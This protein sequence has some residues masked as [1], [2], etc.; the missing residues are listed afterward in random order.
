[1]RVMTVPPGPWFSVA[2]VHRGWTKGLRSVL[3]AGSVVEAPLDSAL[4]FYGQAQQVINMSDDEAMTL[5][6]R[7]VEQ[8]A[9]RWWPQLVVVTSAFYVPPDTL[10]VLRDRGMKVAMIHTESPY[11]DDRQ[12]TR[13]QHADINIVNDP[14]HIDRFPKGTVYIPHAYDPD[15][16]FDDGRERSGFSFVGTGYPSRIEWLEAVAWPTDEVTLAGNWKVPDGSPIRRFVLS[17]SDCMDNGDAADLY[18]STAVGLNLYRKEAT[19]DHL[20]DGWAMGPRE[21]EL[22]A[23]GTFYMTEP[24]GENRE[25]LP[26]VPLVGDPAEFGDQLAWWL[27]HDCE[28]EEVAAAAKAAVADRTFVNNATHLLNMV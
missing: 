7:C 13:A 18:R 9:F 19:H 4:A 10:D 3:G 1:V 22:A 8:M 14:T 21:V 27:A 28:R 25:V 11:E 17:D 15:V 6:S 12:V 23:C 2:D 16:H 26:M 24:R 20:V 5:A